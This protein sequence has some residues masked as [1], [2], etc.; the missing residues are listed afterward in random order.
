[1]ANNKVQPADRALSTIKQTVKLSEY[2]DKMFVDGLFNPVCPNGYNFL[3]GWTS[4]MPAQT[5]NGI[6]EYNISC[7]LN[8]T[9][10]FRN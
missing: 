7:R 8:G 9:A 6:K 4:D 2:P 10:T 1:M 5:P 3:T